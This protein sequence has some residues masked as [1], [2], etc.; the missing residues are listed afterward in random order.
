VAVALVQQITRRTTRRWPQHQQK[1]AALFQNDAPEVLYDD[2]HDV[3]IAL[4]QLPQLVQRQQPLP[5]ALPN[6]NQNAC[7]TNS[8]KV[9]WLAAAA[10]ASAAAA[11][12]A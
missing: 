7:G 9:R 8:G 5:P 2:L 3:A 4:V 6:A 10:S 12:A 11:A 1:A